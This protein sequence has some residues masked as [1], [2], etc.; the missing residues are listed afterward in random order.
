[1]DRADVIDWLSKLT[2]KQLAE[3]F[4]DVARLHPAGVYNI[5][6]QQARYVLAEVIRQQDHRTGQWEPWDLKIVCPAAEP[7]VDDAP[8]CQQ[9]SHCGFTTTGWAKDSVCPLCGGGVYGT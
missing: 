8:I 3:L 5:E 9:G 6:W 2:E 1:M 7:W 4:Y